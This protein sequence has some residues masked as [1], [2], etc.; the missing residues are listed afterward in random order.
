MTDVTSREIRLKSRPTGM[1]ELENFALAERAI[2]PPGDGELRVRNLWMS[3]DPYM[4]GRMIDRESYLPPFRIGEPLQGGA[5]GRVV[6][7]R[8]DRFAVGD[9]VSS[10]HGW[11]EYFLTDGA[12]LQKVDPS[13]GPIQAHLGVLGM[14]GLTAFAGLFRIG[15]LRDGEAVFVSAAAGAVGSV[16]CQLAKAHG[17]RVVGSAGSDAKC[18]WLEQEAGIDAA[19]NYKA[20]GDLTQAVAAAFPNGIDVTFENVGGAHL[21]A[22]LEQMRP[23]GRIALCGMIAQY[24]AAE[25]PPGPR[26]L[27]LAVARSLKL[28]GFI[29]S[30]H[31]DMLADFYAEMAKLI[32]E[33]RMKWKETVDEG[34][35]SAP[36]AFLKLFRGENFGK[37]LVKLGPDPGA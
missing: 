1:P 23:R 16:V 7:S 20:C 31:L 14:P 3:V 35:E 10:M 4:R 25:P 15:E 36:G 32:G 8:N 12:M 37:M 24:N 19:I 33:G 17:C 30:N 34:I 2:G 21:E 5:I 11:R 26:N 28:Q 22:A 6:D 18:A 13:L 27:V 9:Y 29:V